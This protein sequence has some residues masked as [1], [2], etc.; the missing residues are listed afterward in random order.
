[1]ML[2]NTHCKWFNRQTENLWLEVKIKIFRE[3]LVK[4]HFVVLLRLR[5]AIAVLMIN[6]DIASPF[7]VIKCVIMT[8]MDDI[9]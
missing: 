8:K 4:K 7:A 6:S 1:M 3:L 2:L 5:C 9:H